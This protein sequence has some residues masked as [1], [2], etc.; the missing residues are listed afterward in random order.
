MKRTKGR[1]FTGKSERNKIG[2]IK[3]KICFL[4]KDYPAAENILDAVL[5]LA[6]KSKTSCWINNNSS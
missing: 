6:L 4:K 5:D 3:I 2:R 1:D